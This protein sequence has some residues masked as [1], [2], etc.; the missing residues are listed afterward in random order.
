MPT[1]NQVLDLM[2]IYLKSTLDVSIALLKIVFAIA[3]LVLK[4]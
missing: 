1:A 4:A 3:M 2:I